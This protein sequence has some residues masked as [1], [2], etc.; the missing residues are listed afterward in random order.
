[1]TPTPGFTP[2]PEAF[3]ESPVRFRRPE[4]GPFPNASSGSGPLAWRS[5]VL[6][7]LLLVLEPSRSQAED[8]VEYQFEGY[9]EQDDRI[10][11]N[12]SGVYVEKDLNPKLV[13]KGEFVYDAISGATPSGGPPPPGDPQVPTIEFSD[14]RYAGN[15]GLD[16]HQGRFTHTPSVSYS[17]EHDYKS[18]GIAY[19]EAID[20][21]Q[22][23]TT[24]SLGAAHNFDEVSGTYQPEFASKGTTDFLLGVTQL[25]GPRTTFTFNLTLGY[26]DGYLTDPYKGVNFSYNYPDPSFD[27]TPYGVNA[28]EKRPSNRFRQVGYFGINH[29]VK[30]IEGALETTFRLGHDDW[31]ILS[32][33]VGLNWAQK[34][35]RRVI[36]T[37]Q[38]RFYH[39]SA[40]DFY[41]TRFTGDPAYPNGTPYSYNPETNTLLFPGD[42]GYPDGTISDVPAFPDAYSSDYRL[43]EMNTYMYGGSLQ[44]RVAEMAT[45]NLGYKRY[46]MVGTDGVTPES[47]YPTA[48]V[49]SIGFTL[50]F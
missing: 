21:N 30:P 43:S 22:R 33:T 47:A 16:I 7:L 49:Y 3:S 19:N 40:A 35:G 6:A 50:W 41:A 32:Q 38:F 42:E 4:Y 37:P 24:V 45:L 18:F 36:L 14:R 44:I 9:H 28:G 1:M 26:S 12:T 39:Q 34:L 29:Y 17:Y 31:G 27:P 48:N 8:R 23:N 5:G 13:L 11:V 46:H 15:L 2:P 10:A 25:L 20:F